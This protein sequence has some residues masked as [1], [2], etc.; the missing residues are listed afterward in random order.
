MGPQE[1]LA[2][3]CRSLHRFKALV[4]S[5]GGSA[6]PQLGVTEEGSNDRRGRGGRAAPPGRGD[7]SQEGE[8]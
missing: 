4:H 5:H 2:R 8:Q 7:A 1:P 6:I 3:L